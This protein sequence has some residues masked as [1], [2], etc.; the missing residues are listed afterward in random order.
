MTDWCRGRREKD[1]DSEPG[2][3]D[4]TR[5]YMDVDIQL[6]IKETMLD[7]QRESSKTWRE[8]C[9]TSYRVWGSHNSYCDLIG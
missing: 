1:V 8:R 2:Y 3:Q 4:I 5:M 9:K 7:R 6:V